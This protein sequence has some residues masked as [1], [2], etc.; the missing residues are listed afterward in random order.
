MSKKC[1]CTELI[2]Q[3]Y[4]KPGIYNSTIAICPKCGE[5]LF[6]LRIP[7]DDHTFLLNISLAENRKRHD[8]KKIISEFGFSD[9]LMVI[10]DKIYEKLQETAKTDSKLKEDMF[11]DTQYYADTVAKI[12][13]D[14]INEMG[15][16]KKIQE[17]QL[18]GA[19][20][21]RKN[22]IEDINKKLPKCDYH[23]LC[24]VCD[25]LENIPLKE[26]TEK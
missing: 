4:S 19:A 2:S 3:E 18:A 20:Q 13:S 5:D 22:I 9:N 25:V 6:R 14:V 11:K 10:E 17:M 8:F 26:K 15:G 21:L 7:D 24:E 12:Y 16:Y 1:S 23:T